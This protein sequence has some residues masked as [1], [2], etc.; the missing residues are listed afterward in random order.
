MAKVKWQSLLPIIISTLTAVISILTTFFIAKPLGSEIYGKVQFYVGI[1]QVV[2][3]VTSIGL[4][5]IFT[6][7]IQYEKDKKAYFTKWFVIVCAWS[8][9]VYPVFFVIAFYLLTSF[10]QNVLAIALVACCS[11]ATCIS[12]LIGGYLLGDFKQA[13]S[14]FFENLL[15]KII[16]FVASTIIIFVFSVKDNF[17]S[18]Y[19]YIYL[20]IYSIISIL[21]LSL[22]IRKTHLKF[23]KAEIYSLLAFFAISATYMLNNNLAKIIG[24][25]YYQDFDLVGGYSLCVQLVAIA[26][27][28]SNT[29]TTMSKPTFSS[30]SNDTEK[31]LEY[32]R[33]ITRIN[34]FIVIPFCIGFIAQSKSIL[35]LFGSDY[36]P[37]YGILIILCVGTLFS[38]LTGPNGNLL[39][40]SGHEKIELINGIINL[41]TFLIFAFALKNVGI[42][43]LAI[44]SLVAISLVNIIKFVETWIIYKKCPYTLKLIVHFSI[45]L[46]ISFSVFLLIDLI[47]NLYVKLSIDCVAGVGLI[48]LFNFV[49][50][51]KDDKYFFFKK[52]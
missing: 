42:N 14:T 23:T 18:F 48:F 8:V 47:P 3:L 43:G 4:P 36:T 5:N 44:S 35:S 20:A 40:M 1:I 25:E 27:L 12:M 7:K 15:P 16:I 13:Q 17:P 22:L 28:F 50:P 29:V 52:S 31:L 26:S 33:K 2:S 19:L 6:K 34:A 9:I 24:G 39:A 38:N 21:F 10:N 30:L 32:F 46:L 11:F 51:N 45:L 41:L 49:N 37:Y